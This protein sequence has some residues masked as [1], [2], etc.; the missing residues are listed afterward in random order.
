MRSRN[1]LNNIYMADEKNK[2]ITT[3]PIVDFP[4]LRLNLGF[5][6]ELGVLL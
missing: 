4:T 1:Y 6:L 2:H 3:L 5:D